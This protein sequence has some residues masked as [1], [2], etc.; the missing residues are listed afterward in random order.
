MVW[1]VCGRIT[2]PRILLEDVYKDWLLENTQPLWIADVQN[3]DLTKGS[4]FVKR[5]GIK[6]NRI[7]PLWVGETPVGILFANWREAKTLGDDEAE[8]LNAFADLAALVLYE[9]RLQAELAHT[10]HRLERNM[11]LVWVS[12]LEDTWRH[13]FI[14]KAAAIRNYAGT[15]LKMM[16]ARTPV[17][18]AV[19]EIDRL[20]AEIAKAPVRVPQSFEMEAENIPLAQLLQGIAENVNRQPILPGQ[21]QVMVKADVAALADV[22]VK[23][24][25]RWLIYA[26]EALIENARRAM[27]EEGAMGTNSKRREGGQKI[28]NARRA[29]PDEGR[30]M[31]TGRQA[32]Q[33][34]EVRV[35]DKGRGVP[36]ALRD[37]LFKEPM[38]KEQDATGMGLGALLV[39]T[40]IEEHGGS[41]KLEK[42]GPGDTTVLIRLPVTTG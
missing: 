3:H 12:M 35:T 19:Q 6:S 18:E 23:G 28:E 30:I 9:A 1:P 15:L 37:K 40:I 29:M 31:I 10:K 34:A 33:W 7:H 21:P 26:F 39:A 41:V 36:E 38:P 14:Q 27:P 25:R 2:K 32:D 4:S 20:A 11:F 17:K 24:W 5:E 16:P 42:P 8:M 22:Q 13:G